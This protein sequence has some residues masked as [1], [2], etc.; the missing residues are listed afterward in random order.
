MTTEQSA[1]ADPF[2]SVYARDSRDSGA[3]PAAPGAPEQ[4]R[5]QDGT[6]A[7]KEAQQ[8]EAKAEQPP[9]QAE[10]QPPQQE[11]A[12]NRHVPLHELQ[13]EREK[14]KQEAQRREE[15]ERRA[16]EYEGQLLAYQRMLE[17][18]TQPQQQPQE[19]PDFLTDPDGAINH[20][21]M[22]VQQQFENRL[23]NISEAG[24]RRAYGD[25]VVNEALAAAQ[26]AGIN[27]QFVSAQDPYGALISWHKR[28][29]ALSVIGDD[30][31]AYRTKLEKEIREKVLAELKQ[32][33]Q[34]P[35]PQQRFPGSLANATPQGD[36]GSHID[37]QAMADNIFATGRNRR[38]G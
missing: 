7:A 10:A 2:A 20:R 11:P 29:K 15:A 18:R 4:P 24:A 1:S 33:G 37:P 14:R 5:N 17:Q 36:Q 35:A 6:F 38:T 19:P 34:Q 8:P 21:L 9:P 16:S 25:Q 28:V 27:R 12:S 13:S 31:D 30:P 3:D 22:T 32:G 23:L 26:Q